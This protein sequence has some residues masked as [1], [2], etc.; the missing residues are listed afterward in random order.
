MQ[1]CGHHVAMW[2]AS[3]VSCGVCLEKSFLYLVPHQGAP[4]HRL[5]KLASRGV[6]R[7][8][9]EDSLI[10]VIL[11]LEPRIYH[12]TWDGPSGQR[13]EGDEEC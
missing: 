10:H 8:V 13:P 1:I 6:G 12:A 9:V 7:F 3:K 11:G 5:S 4:S 2:P